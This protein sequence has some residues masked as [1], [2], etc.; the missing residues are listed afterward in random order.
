MSS[1]VYANGFIYCIMNIIDSELYVG[2]T[3]K[4]LKERMR[5]HLCDSRCGRNSLLWTQMRLIGG[6]HFFIV[7]LQQFT[8]IPMRELRKHEGAAMHLMQSTLNKNIAGR[9]QKEYKLLPGRK[10]VDIISKKKYALEHI[11]EIGNKRKI[12]YQENKDNIKAQRLIQRSTAEQLVKTAARSKQFY[13]DNRERILARQRIVMQ[14]DCGFTHTKVN[15]S[16]HMKSSRHLAAIA[17]Q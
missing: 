16:T 9:T 14:C 6:E 10:E 17:A 15:R 7:P 11:V 3:T 2:S 1:K 5:S 8:N 13:V 12:Y 4:T